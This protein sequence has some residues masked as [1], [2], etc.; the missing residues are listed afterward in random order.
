M[1]PDLDKCTTECYRRGAGS[2]E[3]TYKIK[4]GGTVKVDPDP[5][6]EY[7]NERGGFHSSARHR[8]KE[9]KDFGDKLGAL[10]GNLK[11]NLGRR[12][13]DVF[14][15]FCH[16]LDRRGVSGHHIWTHLMWEVELN[17]IFLDGE[18]YSSTKQSGYRGDPITGYY[19]HPI[20]GI[21]E[22]K[23]PKRYRYRKPKEEIFPVP[24]QDGWHYRQIDGLWF[25]LREGLVPRQWGFN[26]KNNKYEWTEDGW[27]I[28]E[29]KSANK[30][31]ITWIKAQL[32]VLSK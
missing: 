14:S 22:Y 32:D 9:S 12:W 13:D 15:E 17:T 25:K 19:V 20:T 16:N 2:L 10:R 4:F 28:S 11:A 18:V 30:K 23:K 3:H 8:H 7:D 1:R 6:H 31:E 24:G 21:L 27:I 29:K 5:E 26:W